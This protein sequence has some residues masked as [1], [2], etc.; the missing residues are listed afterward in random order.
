VLKSE[1]CEA[2]KIDWKIASVDCRGSRNQKQNGSFKI[3]ISQYE[4]NTF[5]CSLHILF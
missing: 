5:A 1:W 3:K 2:S 4:E